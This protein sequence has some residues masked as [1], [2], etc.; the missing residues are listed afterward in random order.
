MDEKF[1]FQC[2]INKTVSQT[3]ISLLQKIKWKQHHLLNTKIVH[4]AYNDVRKSSMLKGR[5]KDNYKGKLK[6]QKRTE[7]WKKLC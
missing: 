3:K 4:N 1:Y 7:S 2:N 5:G 6:W